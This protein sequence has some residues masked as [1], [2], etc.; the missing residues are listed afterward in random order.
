MTD[1]LQDKAALKFKSVDVYFIYSF[2]MQFDAL[3]DLADKLKKAGWKESLPE[4]R[5]GVTINLNISKKWEDSRFF[6]MIYKQ[7]EG[8]IGSFLYNNKMAKNLPFKDFKFEILTTIYDMG[9]GTVTIK[10]SLPKGAKQGQKSITSLDL[11]NIF[12]LADTGIQKGKAELPFFN[13]ITLKNERGEHKPFTLLN[14]NLARWLFD[15]VENECQMIE[16]IPSVEWLDRLII[17]IEKSNDWQNPYVIT[18][19]TIEGYPAEDGYWWNDSLKELEKKG[20]NIK[21]KSLEAATLLFR[22]LKG[23]EYITKGLQDNVWI[24]PNL[25]GDES[26]LKNYSWHRNLF[27]GFHPRASLVLNYEKD[28]GDQGV[29]ISNILIN[30]IIK[31][32]EVVRARWHISVALNALLDRDISILRNHPSIDNLI[33]LA[34]VIERR[35]QFLSFLSDPIPYAFEGGIIGDIIE[36]AKEKF[37]LDYLVNIITKKLETM[38]RVYQDTIRYSMITA[39]DVKDM[40]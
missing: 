38:D 1:S 11:H 17:N 21:K 12:N 35:K 36:T 7:Q 9:S 13:D 6:S 14:R 33:F 4:S 34:G 25:R 8:K 27:I 18:V 40:S 19:G 3:D 5:H 15:I 2:F 16:L 32:M 20:N 31:L 24:P 28:Q 30:S 29:G 39:E 26:F 37:F 23:K 22:F 10:F